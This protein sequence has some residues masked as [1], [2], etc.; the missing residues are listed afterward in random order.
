MDHSSGV[1]AD[2]TP[3]PRALTDPPDRDPEAAP[4]PPGPEPVPEAGPRPAGSGAW[5]VLLISV[6]VLLIGCA[7]LILIAASRAPVG[8]PG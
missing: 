3:A 2:E 7:A 4:G 1:T 6:A 5:I 8:A